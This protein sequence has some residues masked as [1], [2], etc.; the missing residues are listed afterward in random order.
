M[1]V[2]PSN[3]GSSS[4]L[5]F[6]DLL[7]NIPSCYCTNTA[8]RHHGSV[9]VSE[10]LVSPSEHLIDRPVCFLAST[11]HPRKVAVAIPIQPVSAPSTSAEELRVYLV[12]SRKHDGKLV[13]PKGGVEAGESSRQAA[14]RELWEEAGLIGEAQPSRSISSI[15]P[16]DLTV[17][18]HKPHK[19]SPSAGSQEPG[20][21]PRARYTGHEVLLQSEGGIKDEWPEKH[22]RERKAF[23]VHQAEQELRW[24]KDIHI[25]F[26]RWTAS[27]PKAP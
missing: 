17:D 26:T 6:T 20:F 11:V 14:V 21:V 27:L 3:A 12:S 25:I 18:D 2:G 23:T 19:K 5:Y 24:R 9:S 16:A 22:E 7:C 8:R 1:E 4:Y 15:S 10:P 13:L